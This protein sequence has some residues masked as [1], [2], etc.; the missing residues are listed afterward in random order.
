MGYAELYQRSLTERDAYWAEQAR[1]IDWHT[2]F[3]RVCN[4]DRATVSCST[5]R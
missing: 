5:C 2:P 4:N 3:S 1:R